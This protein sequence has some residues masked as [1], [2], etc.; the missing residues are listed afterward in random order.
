MDDKMKFTAEMG[1]DAWDTKSYLNIWVCNMERLAGYASLPGSAENTD[2][3]VIDTEAFGVTNPSA[4]YG[5]GRTAVHE[6]GHWLNLRHLWGDEY[7]GDDGVMDTPKQASYNF[8][9][10]SGVRVTCGN[11]P[12][13]DMYTNYMDFTRDNCVNLFTL[14]QKQRM[15]VLF[16]PGG[17]R[18]SILASKGLQPPLISEAP[19]A[20]EPPRWLHPQLYPNPVQTE[21]TLDL[22]YDERWIGKTI[23]IS[24]LNG[25][26]V[27]NLTITSKN[28]RINVSRLQP[29]MYFLAAK[30]PDGESMKLKFIKL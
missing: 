25:Q 29:G 10:P 18:Q 9:C 7:C 3:V 26:I 30:K 24:G 6:A 27:M 20:D 11:S 12:T 21:L 16:E 23:F 22:A 19:V 1:S 28:Q 13:G 14:G 15:R 4:G 5:M 2:G 8:G 17:A